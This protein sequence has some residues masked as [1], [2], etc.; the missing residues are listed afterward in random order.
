MA[1]KILL[2]DDELDLAVVTKRRLES[3]GYEVLT[4]ETG[5][6]ALAFLQKDIPHLILLDLLLPI[7]QGEEVCKRIKCDANLKHVPVILFTASSSD[8]PKVAKEVGADDYIV[9]PFEPEELLGKVRK[10]IG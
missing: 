2:V 9:K 1:G 4:A 8:I 5:E 10:F 6:D 3:A 7:M